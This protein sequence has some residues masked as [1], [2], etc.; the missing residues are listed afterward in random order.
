MAAAA[1][2]PKLPERHQSW[3][4]RGSCPAGTVP[5]LRNSSRAKPE[6]ADMACRASPFGRPGI[7][8]GNASYDL[9]K[10]MDTSKGKVEV[11]I[12]DLA[13]QHSRDDIII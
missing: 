1:S 9:V 2:A 5:I 11:K 8:G 7:I 13:A 6:I 3:R 12:K 4:K 10:S